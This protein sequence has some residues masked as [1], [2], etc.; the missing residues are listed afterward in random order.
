M[1]NKIKSLRVNINSVILSLIV[2]AIIGVAI[3]FSD[4]Y[5]FHLILSI[6]TVIW[7]YQVKE[8]KYRL[9][10]DIFSNNHVKALI[11]IFLWYLLSLVWAPDLILGLKYIFYLFC[12]III[13]ISFISFSNNIENLNTIFKTLSFLIIVQ[14]AI[15]LIES[16]T[17]FRMPISSYSHLAMYFGKDYTNFLEL[18]DVFLYSRFSPP[19]GFH[20][21]T[22][23]LAICMV[24]SL[25]FFLCSKKN[26]IKIIGTLAITAIIVMA[27]SRAVFL[28]LLLIFPLYLIFIKKRIG[29]LSIAWITL[30]IFSLSIHEL[31]ESENPRINEVANS[32]EALTLFLSGEID[33]GGSIEWRRELL[34][35][36]LNALFSS[37]GLGLGAGG[38]VANQEMLGP[39]AGR[40]TS[41]HNFWIELLVEGGVFA[42]IIIFSWILS[43]IYKLFIISRTSTEKA[44][45]YYSES[46]FLSMAAFIPSAISASS[47]IYFFPMWIMF[48]FAISVIILSKSEYN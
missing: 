12:G 6:L 33:V 25:P 44:M 1:I 29:T 36:G 26:H 9:S 14:I 35:N 17:S 30:F 20:W 21:N 37:Y 16:F 45:Q 28:G 42:A 2:S 40:F 32:V 8:N 48:G 46:L 24:I 3:S 27:A 47:T 7:I 13:L 5:L 31:R 4:F 41:M 23:D 43:I 10:L 38:T 18:E 15:A 22:N 19:T 11:V 39:V 34:D